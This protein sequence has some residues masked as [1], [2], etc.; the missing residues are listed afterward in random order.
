MNT[1]EEIKNRLDIAEVIGGYLKLQKAGINYRA[2]CPFHSE[3]SPSFFVSPTRQIWHC[4]GG[5]SEGGDV[6]KFVMKI[7][8]VEFGDALRQLAQKAGMELP[9]RDPQYAKMQTERQKLGEIAEL[10]AQFFQKQL[11]GSSFGKEAKAYLL[12]RGLKEESIL[13]WRIGY[14]PDTP[15]SLVKFLRDREYNEEQMAKA[16]VTIRSSRGSFDRFQSRIMF[17]IF[18]LNSQVV[19]FGGRIFGEKEKTEPAKYMNTPNTL[20]YDKSKLLYGL[21]KAKVAI[22]QQGNCVL[23]EG[24]MD[25]I[26]VS[27]AGGENVVASSGTALTPW[28]LQILKRYCDNLLTAFDMDVAG[29]NATKRGVELAL[30][31]G[32]D[33]K[34]IPMLRKDPADTIAEDPKLWQEAIENA[35]SFLTHSFETSLGRHDKSTAEGKRK[36]AEQLLPLI[37]QIPNKIEQAHWI[38]M[39]AKELQVKEESVQEELK[40]VSYTN[41]EGSEQENKGKEGTPVK[42]RKEMLEE[43]VLSLLVLERSNIDAFKQEYQDYFSLYSQD[44][45]EGMRKNP[46]FDLDTNDIFAPDVAEFLKYVA[47]KGEVEDIEEDRKQ[48]FDSCLKEL[49]HLWLKKRLDTITKDM[50]EAE[51][52]QDEQKVQTLVIEFHKVSREI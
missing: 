5:C 13:K 28:Q 37:K 45:I 12:K 50:R 40:R 26:M 3:K 33:V 9:Q 30:Q 18:D 21:D 16:G 2:V 39:L 15:G 34:V 49:K 20:I 19:G 41:H 47:L 14:A 11:E 42:T 27:Q 36:I 1:I 43:R 38:G 7:E 51:Q 10:T 25:T 48:E 6:F 46:A 17:P 31:K 22:R 4:F 29:D 8:G 24:Y 23:V 52:K 32:F 35:R 44:I